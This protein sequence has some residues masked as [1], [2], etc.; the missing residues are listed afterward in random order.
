M[1]RTTESSTKSDG[2][3][4]DILRRVAD[5]L[6]WELA[7]G[8][9]SLLTTPPTAALLKRWPAARRQSPAPSSSRPQ[10]PT[11]PAAPPPAPTATPEERGAALER[12]AR[13][14][15]ACRRCPLLATRRH[16][17]PGQ[18]CLTPDIM[19]VGE[20][21]GEE[22]DLQGAP[23]VGAA[24]QLLTRMIESM[25]YTREQVFIANVLK[26]RP[27]QNRTPLPEEVQN[28]LPYL[29]EQIRT[30]RPKVLVTLGGVPTRALLGLTA[31]ITQVRGQWRSFEGIPLMPTF[32]PS[33][34]LRQ[35][36]AKREAWED[37]KAVLA[38]LG[39]TPPPRRNLAPPDR[40]SAPA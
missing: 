7:E 15:E 1:T 3:L 9:S 37:L 32:H 22:E 16:A 30:L 8:R 13:E 38:R 36:S 28:C 12:I 40:R 17:V 23:F 35:P 20:A 5:Y 27:P 6:E 4:G 26:C 25:G 2:T 34:L 18:G 14:A 11:P 31:G 33:Y 19:F 21:P 39:R 10:P 24:G 29:R